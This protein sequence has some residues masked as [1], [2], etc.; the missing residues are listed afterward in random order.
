MPPHTTVPPL[1]VAARAAGTR[2]P[3]G[4]KISAA[5]SG[6]GGCSSEPP[7]HT[8]PSERANSC[9]AR[10]PGP[11]EGEDLPALVA[12]HL[13]DDVGGRAKAVNA[14]SPTL[15]SEAQGAVAD[16]P[17][18]QQRRGR[19]IIEFGRDRETVA[20]VG[21]GQLGIAAI[22]LVAG[23]TG[24]VAQIFAAAAAVL[25]DT[26]GP[27]EPWHADPVAD[28]EAFGIGSL[29]HDGADD[30]VAGHQ[31]QLRVGQ[32]AVEDV[33]IGA[34]DGTGLDRDQQLPRSGPRLRQLGGGEGPPGL[35]Q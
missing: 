32:F 26:A 13:R 12:R 31:R 3:T 34:A 18:A 27:A 5:S 10:S 23:E 21:D 16:Q 29:F 17:G 22:D 2:A 30:F 25:A 33:Q 6:S 24:P 28:R 4:A 20:L 11:G 15:A 14:D 1:R 19:D 35:S 7:A 9:A 8:A